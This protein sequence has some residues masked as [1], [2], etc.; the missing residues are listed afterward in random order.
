[1]MHRNYLKTGW[2]FLKKNRLYST[3]NIL[4]LAMGI[5]F[6]W[7]AYLYANDEM[8]YDKHLSANDRLYRIIIDMER[9]DDVNHIGGSSNAMSVQFDEKIPEIDQIAK[10]KSSFGMIK[11]QE[12]VLQQSYLLAD[13]S[14][15]GMLD[16]KFLEGASGT[17]DQPND[18]IIS[19]TLA[20][21]LDLR[22]KA[23]GEIISIDGGDGFENLIIRG[24]Y[25]DI[26]ENTS[27]RRD[28]IVSYANYVASAKPRRLTTWFDINM[29][30]L[31]KL[32]DPTTQKVVE[33]KMTALHLENENEIEE[34]VFIKLQPI[35][36]IHLNSNYGHYNGIVR[37]GNVGMIS[38]F[39][40][41]G[42][43]CLI[44]SIIN[45][46][47]FNI[48]LYIS[49][50]RE[51]ALRKV[52]GAEKSG[53]FSQLITESFL[54]CFLAGVVALAILVVILPFFSDFV[55]K[56][57]NIGFLVNGRFILGAL[58]ILVATSIL[59]GFY[60]AFVLS[61]FSIV[62][63]LKGEQKI[64]SGKWI[65]Q[66]LLAMQFVIASGLVAGMLT[67]KEQVKFLSTFDTKINYD[68]V[69]YMDYIPA[70]ESQIKAFMSDLEQVPQIAEIAA[71]SGYNG[72]GFKYNEED[73]DVRHLRVNR[74][75]IKLLDIDIVAGRSFDPQLISDLTNTVLVNEA[76][77]KKLGLEQP[78]GEVIPFE[79]GDLINPTIIGVVEDYHYRSARSVV[80]PL[81]IY[82]AEEYP[83]QSVYLRLAEGATFDPETL[84]TL[85]TKN[86]DPFPF[87]YSFLQEEYLS[88]YNAE[89]RMMQLVGA[90]CLVSIFLAAMGLL[91]IV[92]LQLNQRFKEISIRKVLGASS[93]NLYQ[94]FTKRYLLVISV[95]L[96]G[97]L[98]GG[99]FVIS[100]WLN[101]YPFHVE[102]GFGIVSL[103]ILFTLAIA[104]VTILSQV[105][106]VVRANPVKFLRDE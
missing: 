14:L 5:S 10:I 59:S 19:E 3:L 29:N 49:R 48:S 50:A 37:G 60:P 43:F 18:V 41:I 24:V 100:K 84:E 34:E 53:I 85:W 11:K 70:E 40:G 102:F 74:D 94:V 46:A 51:V 1:M 105:F 95:G 30:T 38:L 57:Y 39:A 9:N 23:V 82:Q 35:S 101:N 88:A 77:V 47:N 8:N 45:Y 44:I 64:R 16:L 81:V 99:S 32:H 67:M 68:N 17:F 79:Y 7:L 4:G 62:K 22:G 54:S 90:G 58:V 36:E 2:R 73:I 87:E 98:W 20:G 26:P 25:R 93:S 92:G 96:L 27:V 21:K 86:F 33:A 103:T 42:F 97:G 56:N 12:G 69:I 75:L 106:K 13:Q 28:M 31:V 104:F 89:N 91:G 80:D 61:R 15:V 6:C 63:S 83:L 65:T 71:I 52:I 76:L 72:T 78:I 66:S 55:V